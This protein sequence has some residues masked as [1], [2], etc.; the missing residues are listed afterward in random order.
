[1]EIYYGILVL[2]NEL[3]LYNQNFYSRTLHN[4]SMKEKKIHLFDLDSGI[5]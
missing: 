4:S 3:P 2:K 1:M 5:K